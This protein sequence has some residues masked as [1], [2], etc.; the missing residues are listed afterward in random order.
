MV[1]SGFD[2]VIIGLNLLAFFLESADKSR[3]SGRQLDEL[4]KVVPI[5]RP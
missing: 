4:P 1:R 3:L 5:D 2:C